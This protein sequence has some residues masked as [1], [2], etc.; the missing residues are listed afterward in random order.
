MSAAVWLEVVNVPLVRLT[1]PLLIKS[2]G[3]V[4]DV[5]ANARLKSFFIVPALVTFMLAPGAICQ[6]HVPPLLVLPCTILP[7]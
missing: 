2:G 3:P 7:A 6:V 5:G 4:A 1:V